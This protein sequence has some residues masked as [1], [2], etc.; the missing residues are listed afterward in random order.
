[1]TKRVAS[2]FS[3]YALTDKPATGGYKI[4]E[5]Q[6]ATF[7]KS[8]SRADVATFL[9]NAVEDRGWDGTPGIQLGGKKQRH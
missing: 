4:I 1:L 7:A 9:V 2:P 5:K 8:I 3:A 6:A